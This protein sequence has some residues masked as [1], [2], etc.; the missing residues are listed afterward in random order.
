MFTPFVW[1][2]KSENFKK[3]FWYLFLTFFKFFIPSLVLFIMLI[4][5]TKNEQFDVLY[6]YAFY[7]LGISFPFLCVIG[8]FWE[9]TS[10]IINR[11]V[12]IQAAS[13]YNGKVNLIESITLPEL[14]TFKFIWR[15]FASVVATSIMFLPFVMF[16]IFTGFIDGTTGMFCRVSHIYLGGYIGLYV[17]LLFL[18]P[19][20]LWNY[21]KENS[22]VATIDL[23]KAIYIAGNYPLRYIWAILRYIVVYVGSSFAFV[24]L[25][26]LLGV[27]TQNFDFSV[28]YLLKLF[29]LLTF[30]YVFYI[31]SV[32]VY[33]YLLG[34]I[35]PQA[36]A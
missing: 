11:D 31:Y 25:A 32:Y 13:I 29:I 35:A 6:S 17:V 15:G 19:A 10:S 36:E 20:F 12:S 33:A 7:I 3:H 26:L 22:V 14:K 8:Y 5:F 28:F 4:V 24:Q 27:D 21:A 18:M 16:L 34:T 1:M 23:R 2:F 9:L 30:V